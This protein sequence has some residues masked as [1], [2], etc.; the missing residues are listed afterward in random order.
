MGMSRS[1]LDRWSRS[2]MFTRVG[3]G[4]YALAGN[5]SHRAVLE[6]ACRKLTAVVSHQ[7]AAV[8]HDLD[9]GPVVKPSVT[10]PY[11][12]TH[13]Y[14]AVTVHQ[15]TDLTDDQIVVLDGLPVTGPE[16]TIIDLAAVLGERRL[17]WVL[18]RALAAG[19]VDL[20]R[21]QDLFDV[22][23]RR[24]KPG[25]TAMRRL[26]NRRDPGYQPP[27]SALENRLW[28]VIVDAALP[29]PVKQF[30]APWLKPTNGRVDFAY[31]D[32]K[33]VIE[34]DSRQ[35]HLLARSFDADRERDNLAQL[36]GWR[37]LRF[38]WKDIVETPEM[39]AGTIRRALQG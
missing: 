1:S 16:R 7:S 13:T 38:T 18:D 23:G 12:T 2:G 6:A 19:S 24:G 10:V 14:P 39:V 15:T 32:R 27:D 4:V 35:W 31:P 20:E 11:R 17:D 3:R 25:T 9:I 29:R 28:S 34:G 30:R 26:L 37:I 36:A 8:L 22:L 21:L 5:V 33:L